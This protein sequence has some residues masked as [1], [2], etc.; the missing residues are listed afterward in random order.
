MPAS[1]L[2]YEIMLIRKGIE[3]AE[4]KYRIALIQQTFVARV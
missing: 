4:V 3:N 1:N 2:E